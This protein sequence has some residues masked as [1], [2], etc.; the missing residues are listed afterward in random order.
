M[1]ITNEYKLIKI[2]E[3]KEY[4]EIKDYFET[5]NIK[6]ENFNYLKETLSYLVQINASLGVVKFLLDIQQQHN[7]NKR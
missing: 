5:N 1:S 6:P 2:I 7:H 3:N 4:N